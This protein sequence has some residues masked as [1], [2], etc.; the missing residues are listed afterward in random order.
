MR[1]LPALRFSV[2]ALAQ[3]TPFT[4]DQA[5]SA[6]FPTELTAAPDGGKVAWVSNARGVRNIMVAEPPDYQARKI[7]N[8]ALDDGQE[9]Q[10]LRWT[11]DA[12]ALVYV[13]GGTA[14]PGLNPS[15]VSEDVWMAGLDG[16]PP[17]NIGAGSSPAVSPRGGRIAYVRGGQIWWASVD[18]KTAAAHI[19]D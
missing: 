11:P 13:R 3:Q 19:G 1:L 5:L 17:R 15:G 18:G 16:S 12:S 2:A 8:Y 7:T 4:L 9:L 10:N 14:N 6:A